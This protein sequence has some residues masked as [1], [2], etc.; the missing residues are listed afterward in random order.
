VKRLFLLLAVTCLVV[1]GCGGGGS[2]T[3]NPTPATVVGRVLNVETGGPL[4]PAVTVQVGNNTTSTSVADGSF[5]VGANAGATTVIVDTHALFGVWTFTIPPASG[6]TDA[7]D[8]WVGPQKVT[9]TGRVVDSTSSQPI[10]GAT[11]SFAGV[12]GTT[13]ASGIYSL[14]NVAYSSTTQTAFW[15]IQ[16]SAVATGFFA[17][18]FSAAPSIANNGVVTVADVVL[19]PLSDT[20]P[21]GNPANIVGRVTPS[22]KASGTIVTLTITGGNVVRIFNVDSTGDYSFWVPAGNYTVTY[23]NGTATAPAQSVTLST[24]DQVFHVPDVVLNG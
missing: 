22:N 10:S 13:N 19:T 20:T 18:T 7:G 15:G 8:L 2:S 11:V 4:S 16:G 23:Q 9:L 17:T 3:T 1:A 12:T 5:T 14:P 21:P 24:S 6:T